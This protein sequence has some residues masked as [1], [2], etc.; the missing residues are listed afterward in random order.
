M[1]G[2]PAPIGGGRCPPHPP[3]YLGQDEG[4][5]GLRVDG[6]LG[7]QPGGAGRCHGGAR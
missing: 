7:A 3:E 6:G 5:G 1:T 2:R 4:Q